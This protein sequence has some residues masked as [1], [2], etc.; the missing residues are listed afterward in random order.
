MDE[1]LAESVT[2]KKNRKIFFVNI[3]QLSGRNIVKK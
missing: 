2:E 3:N 1:V